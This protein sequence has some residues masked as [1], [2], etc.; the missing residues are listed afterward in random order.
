MCWIIIVR[1]NSVVKF[2]TIEQSKL[3]IQPVQKVTRHPEGADVKI[4]LI[5]SSTSLCSLAQSATK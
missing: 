5:I 4:L 1:L 2:F 3:R